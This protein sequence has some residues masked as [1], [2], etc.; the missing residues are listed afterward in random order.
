[1]VFTG[2]ASGTVAKYILVVA[3][4]VLGNGG[5]LCHTTINITDHNVVDNVY[6]NIWIMWNFESND[7][8]HMYIL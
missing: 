1:M 7:H 4:V 8:L 2:I 5:T 6:V 3:T